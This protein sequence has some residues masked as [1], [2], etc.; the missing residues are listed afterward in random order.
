MK[1]EKTTK[2]QKNYMLS[3]RQYIGMTAPEFE[4]LKNSYDLNDA[5]RRD[6]TLLI[7]LLIRIRNASTKGLW[8]NRSH[9]R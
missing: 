4:E 1:I 6:A 5:H 2:K 9:K 7:K 8:K 3:L